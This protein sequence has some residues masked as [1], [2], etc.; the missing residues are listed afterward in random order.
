MT[1]YPFTGV[2]GPVGGGNAR[3]SYPFTAPAASPWTMNRW[4]M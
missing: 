1:H 4:A 2:D 3:G